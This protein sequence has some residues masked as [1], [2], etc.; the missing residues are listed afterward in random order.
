MKY[1]M[2]ADI[3]IEYET[4]LEGK[5]EKEVLANFISLIV[6]DFNLSIETSEGISPGNPRIV[7][8]EC[9]IDKPALVH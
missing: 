8:Y 9:G 3:T 2:K 6:Q 1:A 4:I 5:S 7:D